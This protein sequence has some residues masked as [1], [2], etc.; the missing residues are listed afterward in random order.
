MVLEFASSE[1]SLSLRAA[2]LE[3][4]LELTAPLRV[5]IMRNLE[6][7]LRRGIKLGR[8]KILAWILD[9]TW[10]RTSNFEKKCFRAHFD[11][12]E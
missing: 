9:L 4:A 10:D 8:T 3:G 6:R 2:I 11:S 1:P 5:V 7:S 12:G